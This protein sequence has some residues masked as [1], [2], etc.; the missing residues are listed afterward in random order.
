MHIKRIAFICLV[1]LYVLSANAQTDTVAVAKPEKIHSPKKAA[2]LS[3]L[4]PGTGQIYNKKYWKA[5]IIYAAFGTLGYFYVDNHKNY[6]HF[7]ESYKFR[8][9]ENPNTGDEYVGVYTDDNLKL[10]RDYYRR[11]TELTVIIGFAVYALNIIDATVDA[12]LFGFNVSDD[13]SLRAE[14]IF[15]PSYQGNPG[16]SGLKL[17]LRF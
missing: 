8:T 2:L 4:L 5:P 10:L 15:S 16:W 1:F 9:D 12:H 17:T 3:S 6:L 7:K 11:N 14:P 13:L